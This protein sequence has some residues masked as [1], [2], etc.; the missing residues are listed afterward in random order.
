MRGSR[1]RPLAEDVVEVISSNSKHV[2]GAWTV[3]RVRE[4]RSGSSTTV[5]DGT[6]L[7]V[8]A[9]L[10]GGANGFLSTDLDLLAIRDRVEVDINA[11]V[12]VAK[13]TPGRAGAVVEV[14]EQARGNR[15]NSQRYIVVL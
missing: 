6:T 14:V 13:A 5:E 12:G 15:P 8:S 1:V 11:G 4:I 7:G 2:S 10:F 3:R 9:N